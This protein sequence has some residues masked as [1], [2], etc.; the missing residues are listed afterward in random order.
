M[1]LL[2]VFSF[3]DRGILALLVEPV[4]ADLELTDTQMSLLLGLAFAAF[5]A[6]MGI[7]F[8]IIADRG[9]RVRLVAVG[10][11]LWTLATALSGRATSFAALFWLRMSVGVGEATLGP[12]APSIISTPGMIGRPGT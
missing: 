6:V 9:N 4:K 11:S 1:T 10:L 5:Y 3:L 8:G 12:A 2:L 7:P